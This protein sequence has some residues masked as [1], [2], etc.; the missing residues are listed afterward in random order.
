MLSKIVWC[1]GIP[2]AS[3]RCISMK[4]ENALTASKCTQRLAVTPTRENSVDI[5]ASFGMNWGLKLP[6]SPSFRDPGN[7]RDSVSGEY[8][9][10]SSTCRREFE[11]TG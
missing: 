10:T 4:A 5:L 7:T 9:F 11:T 8:E 1:T 6:L 2:A 3:P